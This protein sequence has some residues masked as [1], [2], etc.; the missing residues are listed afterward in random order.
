MAISI[1]VTKRE[2]GTNETLRA[3]KKLPAVLYGPQ[4][5]AV[6]IAIDY[7][8]FER[9]WR[10]VGES[11]V[12][13]LTGLEKDMD[14][15]IHDVDVH[16]VTQQIRH[17]DFYVFKAGE[18][19]TVD[20]PLEF[21]GVAPAEKTLGG[22]LIKV[23]HELEVEVLPKDL[24]HEIQVD[25]SAVVDFDSPL[26]VG[27]LKLP[28]GVTPTANADEVVVAATPPKSDAEMEAMDEEGASGDIASIEV[29]GEK[30]EEEIPSDE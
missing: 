18:K 2:K 11:T 27:D 22:T 28:E 7:S 4:Q 12:I 26:H 15:L 5:E 21:I 3:N 30:K 1:E 14:A 19:I 24:P 10:Q 8:T 9:T 16:P 25:V 23:M 6:S 29:E 13:T 20:V 17:A